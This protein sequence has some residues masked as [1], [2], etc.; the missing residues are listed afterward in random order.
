MNSD[1]NYDYIFKVVLVGDSGVGKSSLLKQFSSREFKQEMKATIGVEFSIHNLEIDGKK[2]RTQ[3]WDTAGQ[4]RYRA[5]TNLYYRKAT[6]VLLVYDITAH[7]SFRSL[8]RWLSEARSYAEPDACVTMVGNK[9]DLR[10]LRTVTRL[11]A[12]DF[13]KKNDVSFLETSALDT[14]NVEYAFE[15]LISD[16]YHSVL[17]RGSESDSRI[18]DESSRSVNIDKSGSSSSCCLTN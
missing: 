11:E 10:H 2:V 14:S 1:D 12:E 13:A 7:S 5:I 4:E 18:A 6:G 16:M 17:F 3:I 8:S 15:T 9:S